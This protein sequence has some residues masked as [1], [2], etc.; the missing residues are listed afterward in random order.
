MTP[1]YCSSLSLARP[2]HS[3]S[4]SAK[5]LDLDHGD[6]DRPGSGMTANITP[7][8]SIGVIGIMENRMETTI[9]GYIGYITRKVPDV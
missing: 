4:L 8:Y 6:R 3:V 9:M 1:I 5:L 2:A 7:M